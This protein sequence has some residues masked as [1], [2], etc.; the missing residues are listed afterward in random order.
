[1]PT[2]ADLYVGEGEDAEW[3]GSVPWDGYPEGIDQRVFEATTEAEYRNAV[4]LFLTTAN[5]HDGATLPFQGW[6]WPYRDSRGTH[7]AYTWLDGRVWGSS[8]GDPWFLVQPLED[9]HGE[10]MEDGSGADKLVVRGNPDFPDMRNHQ[11]TRY[12]KGSGLISLTIP[13]PR[14]TQE[15]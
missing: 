5:N 9:D 2:R 6:P 4:S 15:G 10:P 7:Y 12:D 1:M 11:N 13:G 3:L 8:F 14:T